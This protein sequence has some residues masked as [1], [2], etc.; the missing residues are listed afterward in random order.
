MSVER[1]SEL[2]NVAWKRVRFIPR[3]NPSFFPEQYALSDAFQRER[4]KEIFFFHEA[5]MISHK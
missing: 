3:Y 2:V 5:I 4:G 1:E